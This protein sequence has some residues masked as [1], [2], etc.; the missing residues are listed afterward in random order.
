MAK[1]SDKSGEQTVVLL[2]VDSLPGIQAA[3]ILQARGIDI[4]G[5]FRRKG[6]FYTKTNTCIKKYYFDVQDEDVVDYLLQISKKLKRGR[7][8]LLPCTDMSALHVSKNQDRLRDFYYFTTSEGSITEMLIHKNTFYK[9]LEKLGLNYPKSVVIK[10]KKDLGV[11]MQKL[12]FP[13]MVKPSVRTK[14]WAKNTLDK[15]YLAKDENELYKI[16]KKCSGWADSLIVQEWIEGPETNLVSCNVYYN[17]GSK[18]IIAY[19]ARK[20]RQWPIWLGSSALGQE[21]RNDEVK[22][23]AR[24]VFGNIPFKGLG[25]IETKRG[26]D[27]KYYV[28]EANIGRPTVRS[29][30]V[31]AGGVDYLYTYCL[32]SIYQNQNTPIEQKYTG[33]KW[34]HLHYDTRSALKFFFQGKLGI[35]DYLKSIRG[36]TYFADFSLKDPWPFVFDLKQTYVNLNI[37]RVFVKKLSGLLF[38]WRKK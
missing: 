7:M 30:I 34:M 9:Y 2:G 19:T 31:E 18:E 11:C 8:I 27:G 4:V 6:H 15:G 23:I 32:D 20:I 24:K 36:V 14:K 29:S 33:A 13:L 38:F 37:F 21:V 28:L 1:L 17:H 25:Y 3:R 16:Y 12:S 35:G 10:D 26:H 22:K 5:I